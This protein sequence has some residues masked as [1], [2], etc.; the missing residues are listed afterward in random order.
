MIHYSCVYS[1]GTPVRTMTL[2]TSTKTAPDAKTQIEERL[3]FKCVTKCPNTY[4]EQAQITTQD[5][6]GTTTP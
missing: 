4:E 5:K 6:T 1:A 2:Y 3:A